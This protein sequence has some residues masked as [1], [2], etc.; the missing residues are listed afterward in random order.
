VAAC[1]DG[2]KLKNGDDERPTEVVPVRQAFEAAAR[3]LASSG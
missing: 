3:R 2:K 1:S